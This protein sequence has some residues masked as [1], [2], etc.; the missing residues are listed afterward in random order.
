MPNIKNRKHLLC[1]C[2]YKN[3]TLIDSAQKLSEIKLVLTQVFQNIKFFT[4][5]CAIF[6]Y[7]LEIPVLLLK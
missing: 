7:I 4:I 6:K 5:R 2:P 1:W 3:K